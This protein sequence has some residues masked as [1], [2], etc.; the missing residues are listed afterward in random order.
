MNYKV[1]SKYYQTWRLPEL[2]NEFIKATLAPSRRNADITNIYSTLFVLNIAAISV[3]VTPRFWRFD[4]NVSMVDFTS[5]QRYSRPE[6]TSIYN[7]NNR[8][9]YEIRNYLILLIESE[10]ES[11]IIFGYIHE[12]T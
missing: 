8:L 5:E 7:N 1:I 6:A 12:V 11:Y 3:D 10:I 4:A 9:A 2:D